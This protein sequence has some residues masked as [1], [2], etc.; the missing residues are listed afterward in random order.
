VVYGKFGGPNRGAHK[1]DR[2]LFSA[3]ELTIEPGAK[4]TI[5]D[6]GAYGL[7]TVQGYGRV[8]KHILQS[9]NMIRFGAMT[10]DEVFVSHEAATRGVVFENTGTEPLVTLRYFGPDSAPM[11][12][13]TGAFK[14]IKR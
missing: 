10:E 1:G 9:P 2:D 3:K 11:A 13:E 7:I 14:T 5:K 6:G 8:G 4:A 12:P